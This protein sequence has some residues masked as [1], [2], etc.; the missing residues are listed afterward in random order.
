MTER[1]KAYREMICEHMTAEKITGNRW[2]NISQKL[3]NMLLKDGEKL[4]EREKEDPYSAPQGS[5]LPA[6][7]DFNR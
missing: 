1:V 3:Y 2:R 4:S 7:S 6:L 5:L